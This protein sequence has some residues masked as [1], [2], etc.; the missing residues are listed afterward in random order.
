MTTKYKYFR[1]NPKDLHSKN[2]N[3]LAIDAVKVNSLVLDIGCA[4]GSIGEYLIEKKK[5]FVI[6]IDNRKSEVNIAKKRL[7][8]VIFG[9]LNKNETFQ[10]INHKFDVV[11]ATSVVE[12]LIDPQNTLKRVRNLLKPN[13][14]LIVST[15]NIVH[16][17]MRKKI[18]KGNF[19]YE[20]YGILDN[21]H[22]HFYTIKTFKALVQESGYKIN[23][24][25]CDTEGGGFPKL[26]IFLGKF[27]PEI[28]AYQILIEAEK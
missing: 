11:L 27:F 16:W 3:R 19:D 9:D 17:S 14:K 24:V 18:I 20:E 4:S 1:F 22:L 15:P 23:N 26:S 8:E 25:K 10:K 12:H 2:I 13:G 6:G 5:C 28:F 21:T 7:N